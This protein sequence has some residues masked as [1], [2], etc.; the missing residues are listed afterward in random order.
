MKRKFII[1]VILIIIT[2]IG[3]VFLSKYYFDSSIKNT[4]KNNSIKSNTSYEKENNEKEPI[5]QTV[6]EDD[7]QSK[8]DSVDD[9]EEFSIKL[10]FAGDTMLA[11]YKDQTT[12]GSFNDYVNKKDENYFLEK[13]SNIFKEDDFTILNLEN[14]L[15]DQA[16]PEVSKNTDPA[17]WYKSKTSNINILSSSSGEG[18]SVSNNHTGDYGKEGKQDTINAIV[19]ANMQYGDYNHIMYF[20]KNNYTIAIICKGLWIESQAN[21]IIKL[22]KNAKEKS[23]YQ[24]IFF[25]GGKERIHHPEDWKIR[26]TRKLIDNG[27]DL[28]VGSHPHVIQPREI[29]KEKEIVYSLGNFCY[30]GNKGPENRTIIYQINLTIDNNTK[31][32]IKEESNIIPCYVYTG[33]TNNYQPAPIE[34]ESIKN[35]VIDFMNWKIDS[36]L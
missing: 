31:E 24:I 13:V 20:K 22:I 21:D 11:S 19:N 17:Y 8:N 12:P 27:A 5:E 26:A 29:Y 23:D 7:N 25:H 34:K 28:V 15:T 6:K 4:N 3:S 14:V 30:G 9:N 33:N 32:L 36:P 18:V 2:F 1:G 10:S 35:K 16:L